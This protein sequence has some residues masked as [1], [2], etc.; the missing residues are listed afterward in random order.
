MPSVRSSA[1]RSPT[2]WITP[3]GV[4]APGAEAPGAGAPPE[5]T[6]RHRQHTHGA[7]LV[8]GLADGRPA[9]LRRCEALGVRRAERTVG[10]SIRGHRHRPD[11]PGAVR[12]DDAAADDG[13]G[14]AGAGRAVDRDDHREG[15]CIR[16]ADGEPGLAASAAVTTAVPPTMT[17]PSNVAPVDGKAPFAAPA[18]DGPMSAAR[19]R[20]S[21][22]DDPARV[23]ATAA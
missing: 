14:A 22:S 10:G 23:A 4:E 5:P 3:A 7:A 15:T 17:P 16:P 12:P 8:G 1:V 11:D 13:R 20:S 19:S 21:C 6:T 2:T 9:G 18:I